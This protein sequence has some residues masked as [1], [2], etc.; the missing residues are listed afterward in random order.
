MPIA[1][2]RYP[3][4]FRTVI[5]TPLGPAL[6]EATRF[7]TTAAPPHVAKTQY[8]SQRSLR[9]TV[10]ASSANAFPSPTTRA[11]RGEGIRSLR[12]GRCASRAPPA[13]K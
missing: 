9:R 6:L 7:V 1:G 4:P 5:P 2:T 11:T 12:R 10:M 13:E 8:L 3:V